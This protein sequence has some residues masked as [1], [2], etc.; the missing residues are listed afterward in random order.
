MNE[1]IIEKRKYVILLK[2]EYEALRKRAAR[3]YK[4]EKK[5][6]IAEARVQTKKLIRQW[7]GVK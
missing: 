7:A 5:I 2:D 6:T 3:K 1:V 4:P